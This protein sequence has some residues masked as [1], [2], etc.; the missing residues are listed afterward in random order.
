[1]SDETSMEEPRRGSAAGEDRDELRFLKREL[2]KMA[3]VQLHLRQKF[4]VLHE[5]SNRLYEALAQLSPVDYPEDLKSVIA[6]DGPRT[7]LRFLAFAGLNLGMGMPPFEFLRSLSAR[8]IP[9]WF[10]KDFYQSWYQKGLLGLT[11]SPTETADYLRNLIGD[12]NGRRLVTL[13]ASSGGYAAILYGCWLGAEKVLAFSPQS[14]INR[15]IV[16]QYAAIDTPETLRFLDRSAGILNLRQF[17]MEQERAPRI[18]VYYGSDHEQDTK[19]ALQLEGLDSVT[20]IPVPGVEG[21]SITGE[22]RKRGQLDAILD[23]FITF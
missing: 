11:H 5:G 23:D 18:T 3:R 6:I 14:L 15:R 4:E 20:L 21:H 9:G 8:D 7:D 19:E 22:L 16:S 17:L 2:K 10:I 12:A 13:G 1:M